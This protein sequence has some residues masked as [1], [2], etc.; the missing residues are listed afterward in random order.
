MNINGFQL[1][2]KEQKKFGIKH[3]TAIDN[4]NLLS[5]KDKK[6]WLDKAKEIRNNAQS[7]DVTDAVIKDDTTSI[8]NTIDISENNV[9]QILQTISSASSD[10]NVPYSELILGDISNTI[11]SSN[12]TSD[13][14]TLTTDSSN[15]LV[16]KKKSKKHK[17]DKETDDQF[18]LSNFSKINI[19]ERIHQENINFSELLSFEFLN[20]TDNLFDL[21]PHFYNNY[22]ENILHFNLIRELFFNSGVT[23][24]NKMRLLKKLI[25]LGIN[26]NAYNYDENSKLF[27]FTMLHVT[28][29]C[30][31][32]LET[33]ML[34]KFGA[35]ITKKSFDR[36]ETPLDMC[37]KNNATS[38]LKLLLESKQIDLSG[39]NCIL[40]CVEFKHLIT[41]QYVIKILLQYGADLNEL[42]NKN[43]NALYLAKLKHDSQLAKH[44]IQL[45]AV[46]I[47]ETWKQRID[48]YKENI[49]YGFKKALSIHY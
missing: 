8:K 10:N 20:S 12:N 6:I 32:V 11:I 18:Y 40:R 26:L 23:V 15:N 37:I 16:K 7:L 33:E 3:K 34:L 36:Y 43:Q 4:W 45:G 46:P 29:G 1:Y 24:R 31:M 21:L 48:R 27:G 13:D 14:S 38:T 39:T 17:K 47:D 44:L 35:S 2:C 25:V 28:C 49:R 22:D 41:V 42:N 30:N 19:I 9:N 5:R